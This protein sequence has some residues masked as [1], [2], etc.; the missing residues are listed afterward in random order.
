MRLRNSKYY[1]KLLNISSAFHNNKGKDVV[2]GDVGRGG[3]LGQWVWHLLR[4]C[5]KYARSNKKKIICRI[6]IYNEYPIFCQN[7]RPQVYPIY[8]YIIYM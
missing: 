7:G 2:I 8:I 5:V 4:L 3:G 1:S 6:E